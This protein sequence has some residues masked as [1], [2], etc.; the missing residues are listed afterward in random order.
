MLIAAPLRMFGTGLSVLLGFGDLAL[1]TLFCQ[2]ALRGYFSSYLWDR[3][4][5]PYRGAFRRGRKT[6]GS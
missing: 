6:L 3:P 1:A 4:L 5:R 2:V